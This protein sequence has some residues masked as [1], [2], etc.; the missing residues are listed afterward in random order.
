MEVLQLYLA[1]L[2]L[3][4]D[5]AAINRSVIL[6]YRGT[7]LVGNEVGWTHG[8]IVLTDHEAW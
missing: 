4:W 1:R 3:Q 2:V 5:G 6:N 7:F 8:A